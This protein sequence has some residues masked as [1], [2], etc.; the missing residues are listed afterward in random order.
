LVRRSAAR[1]PC[2]GGKPVVATIKAEQQALVIDGSLIPGSA[3][4]N[5]FGK[6]TPLLGDVP[7][8]SWLAIGQS[9]FGGVVKSLS[10]CSPGSPAV[11]S[12]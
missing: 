1:Q 9:D 7:A 3:V 6:S 10:G 2:F 12:S 11:R 8:D 5:L 4:L